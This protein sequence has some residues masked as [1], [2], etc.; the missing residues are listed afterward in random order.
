[1]REAFHGFIINYGPT[2]GNV[3]ESPV[4][5]HLLTETEGLNPWLENF[6]F[7]EQLRPFIVFDRGYWKQSRFIELDER[8]WGWCIPWKKRTLIGAQ[9]ELLNFPVSPDEPLELLVWKKKNHRP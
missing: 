5:D 8:G 7:D 4:A 9:L 6:P 1:V 2:A 3:H